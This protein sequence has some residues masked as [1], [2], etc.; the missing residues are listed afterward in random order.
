MPFWPG[1]LD[2][3]LLPSS[4][5]LGSSGMPPSGLRTIPPGFTRGL[6]FGDGDEVDDDLVDLE[7]QAQNKTEQ[8]DAKEVC[9]RF[10]LELYPHSCYLQEPSVVD[11]EE[12]EQ[13]LGSSDIDDLL[14]STVCTVYLY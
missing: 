3:V 10:F 7:W 4:Q 12:P 13:L 11:F 14:P 9:N 2:D 1:G 6:R 8:H 5:A